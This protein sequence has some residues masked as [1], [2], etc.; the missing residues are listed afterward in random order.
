ML[1]IPLPISG[2]GRR[3]WLESALRRIS[4]LAQ[5][6]P[7]PFSESHTTP[8]PNMPSHKVTKPRVALTMSWPRRRIGAV[9]AAFVYVIGRIVG[10]STKRPSFEQTSRRAANA[11]EDANA[12]S[13]M[14]LAYRSTEYTLPDPLSR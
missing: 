14:R 10:F 5:K 11:D 2:L 3:S 12:H 8:P 9:A 6:W 7:L 4:A 13:P 1:G